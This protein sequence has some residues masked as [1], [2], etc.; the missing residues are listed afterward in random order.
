MIVVGVDLAQKGNHQ[1][2]IL[3]NGNLYGIQTL[4]W[5]VPQ[6][7]RFVGQ[8]HA[9]KTEE[10]EPILVVMEPTGSAWV[11]MG[12]FFARQGW[13]NFL[14]KSQ[15]VFDLRKF[16]QQ[17]VKNDRVDALTLAQIPSIHPKALIAVQFD[18]PVVQSLVRWVKRQ[19][20][21]SREISRLKQAIQ[22][23]AE[24]MIPG[25]TRLFPNL[26]TATAQWVFQHGLNPFF[27]QRQGYT[28][29]AEVIHMEG[30]TWAKRPVNEVTDRFWALVRAACDLYATEE[31]MD[32]EGL[33]LEM[34]ADWELLMILRR[35]HQE[36]ARRARSCYEKLE[37]NRTL[38]SIYGVGKLGA[39]VF[40]AAL[41]SHHFSTA[42]AFRGYTGLVPKVNQSGIRSSHGQHLTKAGPRWLKAQLYLAAETARRFDPQLAAVYYRER[43]EK[44]HVHTQAVVAV[45]TRLADRIWKV[46]TTGKAYELRDLEGKPITSEEARKLIRERFTLPEKVKN[47]RKK[48]AGQIGKRHPKYPHIQASA[49]ML[50][51][52]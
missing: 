16:F 19:H 6:L 24:A 32:W 22:A 28:W 44:G 9:L 5:D 3:Q 17:H 13:G 43:V 25:I 2:A 8:V 33:V 51:V 47:R 30:D 41:A 38:E 37:P 45:A 48:G 49:P 7:E 18:Q 11:T 14:V 21:L 46:F 1:A 10:N 52:P 20:R 50:S 27:V 35:Q 23:R 26:D 15:V 40:M 42:K 34:E 12:Q 31:T 39:P 4:G 36:A 29:L